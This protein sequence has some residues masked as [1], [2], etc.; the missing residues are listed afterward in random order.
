MTLM[1]IDAPGPFAPT[2]DLLAFVEQMK[3]RPNQDDWQIKSAIEQAESDLEFQKMNG[4]YQEPPSKKT[5]A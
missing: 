4:L 5:A 2:Q 3:K 1:C